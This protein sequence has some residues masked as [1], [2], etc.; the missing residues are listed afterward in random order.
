M[1]TYKPMKNWALNSNHLIQ[2]IELIPLSSYR[3][4]VSLSFIQR[5]PWNLY[6][7]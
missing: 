4:G 2:T 7:V 1:M 6:R 5:T 3:A